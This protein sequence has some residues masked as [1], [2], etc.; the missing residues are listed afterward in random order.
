MLKSKGD[1]TYSANHIK[2]LW[3]QESIDRGILYLG[4]YNLCHS[5]SDEG[6]NRLLEV[7]DEAF[8]ILKVVIENE[9][10]LEQIHGISLEQRYAPRAMQ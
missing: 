7:Y 8:G 4:S 2:S 10:V 6:I 1:A 9:T 5:H 3:Q